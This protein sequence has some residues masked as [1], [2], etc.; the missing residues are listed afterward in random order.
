[1][2]CL[3]H[4]AIFY[5][6]SRVFV[7]AFVALT[8]VLLLAGVI[9]EATRNGLGPAQILTAI[10]LLIPSTIPYTLPTTTLF[11]CCM[12]YG[13]L[14]QDN[15]ILAL[16]AAGIHLRH[17]LWPAFVLGIVASI[18]TFVLYLHTIPFTHF[19]LRSQVTS[20]VD[21]LL[22]GMLRRESCIRHPRFNYEIY[23]KGMKGHK[24][25]DALFRRRDPKGGY[26]IVA[27][28]REAEL[29]VDMSHKRIWVRMKFC[30]TIDSKGN[31][32]AYFEERVWPVDLPDDFS[33][34]GKA[35][36]CDMT[37]WELFE[38]RVEMTE[39]RDEAQTEIDLHQ[40]RINLYESKP[41]IAEH[42]K[43]KRN[44]LKAYN[45]LLAGIDV[46]MH[47]RPAIAL[48][49]LCFALVGCPVGIWF[50][51]SDYLSAFITCFLPIVIVYYPLMLCAINMAKTGKGF[52][53]AAIWGADALML[54]AAAFMYRR[55]VRN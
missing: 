24:L 10:P 54:I 53:C 36:G 47:Q 4:R 43:H 19:I 39:K 14:S 30:N 11:A 28:A 55:L 29:L 3:L 13:R 26:D 6:L 34:I 5:E 46:E 33:G 1:M 41:E 50:S 2:F 22:Y 52:T 32:E 51:K 37:W 48:G 8:G 35:R 40:I 16:R 21:E 17:A 38:S 27:Y 23:I 31:N 12:V 7:L 9:T 25:Q 15:E 20:D 44:D 42:I 45:I 18:V 49:C